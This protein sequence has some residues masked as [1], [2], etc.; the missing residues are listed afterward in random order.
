[1]DNCG[2]ITPGVLKSIL[3]HI[4]GN[5]RELT[6]G[7][8]YSLTDED[9]FSFLAQLPLLESLRLQYYWQMRPPKTTPKLLRLKTFSVNYAPVSTRLEVI[10]LCRWIKRVIM[11]SPIEH[12][13]LIQDEGP[14]TVNIPFDNLLEHLVSKHATTLRTLDCRHAYVTADMIELLLEHCMGLEEMYL[15]ARKQILDLFQKHARHLPN[16]H[17]AGFIIRNAKMKRAHVD[18]NMAQMILLNGPSSL[19]RLVV[20]GAAWA[21]TVTSLSSRLTLSNESMDMYYE[22]NSKSALSPVCLIYPSLPREKIDLTSQCQSSSRLLLSSTSQ[23]SSMKLSS[24]LLP[25]LVYS[26]SLAAAR[27]SFA[28]RFFGPG[29]V[30]KHSGSSA[31][32]NG[33]I[34]PKVV[35]ISMFAPEGEAW[36]GIPEFDVLACNISVVGFSPLFPQIHCT[37]D[38]SICQMTLGEAEI[39]AATSVT[40]LALSPLF[41]LT[42][43]YFMIAGIAGVNPKVT[44]VNSV[45]FA[46]Y[47]VQVAL[48]YEFDARERPAGFPTGYVPQGSTNPEEYPQTLYGTEVFEVNDEL[49]KLAVGFA[50][51]AKLEDSALTQSVRAMYNTTPDF[52]PAT[53]PPSVV[54]CDTATADV[55]WTGDLLGEAFENTTRLFTNGSA[56]YCSTQQED[57]GTLEALLRAA[58]NHL[59]DFSRIIV[60]RSASDFDRPFAGE[61]PAANLFGDSGGFDSSLANIHLAGVKVVEGIVDGWSKTFE[62]GVK[63]QNYIGDIFAGRSEDSGI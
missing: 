30:D 46:R 49:R 57:N 53:E 50:S 58:A 37:K 51:A 4:S 24:V 5:L 3:P 7:L 1:M 27:S 21:L 16:L 18:D 28:S 47:A 42:T 56:T 13:H 14:R 60:M 63:P 48:Q 45:T 43:T 11:S 25:F 19:R 44:T 15:A 32:S 10:A 23:I 40:A 22:G 38:E 33:K 35:I 39:N 41:D 59:V 36:Y 29:S 52:K 26:A 12:I 31:H 54:A 8:S 17:T 55:F 20:N 62:E 9:V 6:L 2:S 61:T 34:K